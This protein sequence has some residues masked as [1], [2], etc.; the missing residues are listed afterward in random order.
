MINRTA[1]NGSIDKFSATYIEGLEIITNT[2]CVIYRF[3]DKIQIDAKVQKYEIKLENI[4]AATV[5]SE[6]ELIEKDKSVVGRAIIGT[7]LVPGLGTII[8]G[9]SGIGKKKKKGKRNFYLIINY[10]DSDGELSTVTFQ[11]NSNNASMNRF[12]KAINNSSK[13]FKPETIQL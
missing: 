1:S 11:N 5:K 4:R 3:E 13:Q 8:G 9:L 12:C 7:L 10:V 6:Q 2:S